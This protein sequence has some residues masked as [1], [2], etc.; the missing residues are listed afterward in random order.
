MIHTAAKN[1]KIRKTTDS[2]KTTS[3]QNNTHITDE[4]TEVQKKSVV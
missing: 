4:E 1:N 2:L 3:I